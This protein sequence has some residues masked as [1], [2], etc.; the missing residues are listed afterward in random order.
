MNIFGY[1]KSLAGIKD[2]LNNELLKDK[3]CRCDEKVKRLFLA[4]KSCS[5]KIKNLQLRNKKK[6]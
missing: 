4:K 3:C 6:K 1:K 5:L 2:T